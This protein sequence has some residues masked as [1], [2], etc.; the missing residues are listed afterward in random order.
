M[1]GSEHCRP[2]AYVAPQSPRQAKSVGLEGADSSGVILGGPE[3]LFGRLEKIEDNHFV[4]Q[5]NRDNS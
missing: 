4:V 5:G 1:A 2:P 3:I